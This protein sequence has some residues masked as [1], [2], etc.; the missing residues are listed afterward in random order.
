MQCSEERRALES[1]VERA[2]ISS[3]LTLEELRMRYHNDPDGTRLPIKLD[4]TTNGEFAPV[5]LSP[6]HHHARAEARARRC[7]QSCPALGFDAPSISRLGLR[8]GEHA[9][10]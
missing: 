7:K 10:R 8:R 2:Y 4:P 5:P 1:P 6:V 3:Q 9:A